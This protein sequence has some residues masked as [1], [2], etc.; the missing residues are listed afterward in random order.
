MSGNVCLTCAKCIIQC[1]EQIKLIISRFYQACQ[2][3]LQTWLVAPESWPG[4]SFRRSC[5]NV[6]LT[7]WKCLLRLTCYMLAHLYSS[8]I[9]CNFCKRAWSLVPVLCGEVVFEC[10]SS[11]KEE[12]IKSSQKETKSSQFDLNK[13]T[14]NAAPACQPHFSCISKD[15]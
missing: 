14:C 10:K 13:N 5:R 3:C 6:W 15:C 1:H 12:E 2:Y 11:K 4:R 8:L 7:V 9:T